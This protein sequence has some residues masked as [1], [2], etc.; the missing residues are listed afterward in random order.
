MSRIGIR[1]LVIVIALAVGAP[2]WAGGNF[3]AHLNGDNQ[4]PPFDTQAQGQFIG[5]LRSGDALSYKLNVAN[6]MNIV[7]AHIHCA[8]EGANGP[9][10]VTLFLGAP[11]SVNG[12]L[13][14]GPILAPDANNGCG[15]LD[16]VDVIDALESGDT[17][18]NVHTLQSLPG[19]IRG[20]VK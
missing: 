4:V 6:I 1:T 11:M 10:G 7:A 3:T 17:Y 16:L 18:I 12:T 5:K 19:E 13:A 20:Q 8:P 14:Q 9:V 15:W 2:A